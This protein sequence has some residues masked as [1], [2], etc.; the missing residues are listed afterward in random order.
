MNIQNIA[1]QHYEWSWRIFLIETYEMVKSWKL[2]LLLNSIF[3]VFCY[4]HWGRVVAKNTKDFLIVEKL[5]NVH[6]AGALRKPSSSTPAC[7]TGQSMNECKH[8]GEIMNEWINVSEW[9]M[10]VN[11]EINAWMETCWWKY[12]LI[13]WCEWMIEC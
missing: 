6:N 11:I 5:V 10:N 8:F 13:N 7:L 9:I 12:E 2:C 3:C 4:P 1:K